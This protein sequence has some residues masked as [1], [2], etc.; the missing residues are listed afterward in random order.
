MDHKTTLLDRAL[1]EKS[2][3]RLRARALAWPEKVRTIE[4]LRDATRIARESMR[5]R[6]HLQAG[7]K[8]ASR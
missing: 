4:R 5:A 6:R 3:A 2:A 8:P 7:S 1:A